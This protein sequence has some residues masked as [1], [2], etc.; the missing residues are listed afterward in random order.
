VEDGCEALAEGSVTGLAV[1]EKGLVYASLF[2]DGQIGGERK[3]SRGLYQLRL[4]PNS[5]SGKW[6]SVAGT[7]SSYDPES[8]LTGTFLKLWGADGEDLVIR[9]LYGADM[10]WVRVIR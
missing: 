9:R 3:F 6:L 8:I 7:L 10:S 4:D 5:E 1:T 2:G